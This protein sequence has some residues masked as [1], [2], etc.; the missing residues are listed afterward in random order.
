ASPQE[1]ASGALSAETESTAHA[2]FREHGSIVMRGAFAPAM[3]EA[4]HREYVAQLGMLDLA[5]MKQ[6]AE[7]PPPNR[8]IGVG[9]ARYDITL[10]M[11]GVFGRTEVFAN[12]L[13]LQ[14]LRPL[15][16]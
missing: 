7:R 5:A 11:T 9:R 6:Q 1:T 13:L 14:F 2:A 12:G 16:G 8:L 15:L 4:M 3:V 10:R